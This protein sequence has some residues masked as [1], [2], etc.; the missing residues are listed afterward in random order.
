MRI[1][2]F[3]SKC[4]DLVRAKYE[5]RHEGGMLV[6]DV[7]WCE[8][9]ETTLWCWQWSPPTKDYEAVISTPEIM[10]KKQEAQMTLW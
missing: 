3:C 4:N 10:S 1:T 7:S 2:Q 6:G 9:C 8:A 5:T